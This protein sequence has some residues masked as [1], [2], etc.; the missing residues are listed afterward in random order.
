MHHGHSPK[1][2]YSY[3][4]EIC[5][6]EID[7]LLYRAFMTASGAVG[8]TVTG[9]NI[10]LG[11]LSAED[12]LWDCSFDLPRIE[13]TAQVVNV[14]SHSLHVLRRI[15]RCFAQYLGKHQPYFFY[16][17][18]PPDR[19]VDSILL[20]LVARHADMAALYDINP[21][22]ANRRVVFTRKATPGQGT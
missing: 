15:A 17:A 8:F 12:L 4:G 9:D 21:D 16:Y 22:E 5:R 6:F 10:R 2:S 13:E 14:H 1:H 3:S 7:E 19:R 20:R 18:T 11:I